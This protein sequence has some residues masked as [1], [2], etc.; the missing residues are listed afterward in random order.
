M[1]EEKRERSMKRGRRK[2]REREEEREQ[3][4]KRESEERRRG[5]HDRRGR[6]HCLN[7]T[8]KGTDI[9]S[10]LQLLHPC[11]SVTHSYHTQVRITIA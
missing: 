9:T 6:R 7:S 2:E 3:E 5:R 8:Q 1:E 11:H 10:P 4:D